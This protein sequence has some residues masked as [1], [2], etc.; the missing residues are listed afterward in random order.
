MSTNTGERLS[1]RSDAV[2]V[3]S[4]LRSAFG[5]IIDAIPEGVSRPHEVH[6]SLEIANG[7]RGRSPASFRRVICSTQCGTYAVRRASTSS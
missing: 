1:F 7:L 6:K 4:R 3:L 5:A 2:R